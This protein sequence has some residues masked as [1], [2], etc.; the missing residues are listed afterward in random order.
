MAFI[1]SKTEPKGGSLGDEWFNP[2][3]NELK[4]LV[5]YLGTKPT[6]VTINRANTLVGNV[7][8]ANT[9]NSTNTVTSATSIF[10]PAWMSATGG[11]IVIEGGYAYH[12]FN[13]S[14]TFYLTL[15]TGIGP[16]YNTAQVLLIGGG[17][18]GGGGGFSGTASG[19]GGGGGAGGFNE[20]TLSNLNANVYSVI[21]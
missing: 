11:D 2:D 12:T 10:A 14:S 20:V 9:N 19:A 21:V 18:G 1:V 7:V 4:K 15:G 6:Y 8:V 13:T 16:I 3:T 5:P 17:G